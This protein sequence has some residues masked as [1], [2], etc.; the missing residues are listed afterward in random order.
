[1][2]RDV[3][4]LVGEAMYKYATNADSANFLD[5]VKQ[6]VSPSNL[7]PEQ[8]LARWSW[9]LVYQ[10]HLHASDRDTSSVQGIPELVT[11][12]V[13]Q[14]GVRE[15]QPLACFLTLQ[16]TSVGH[17]L[18]VVCSQ[19]L[20]QLEVLTGN[21]KHDAVLISLFNI[22]PLFVD[23]PDNL[24]MCTSFQNILQNLLNADRTYMKIAKSFIG[25]DFPGTVLKH[26][27]NMIEMQTRNPKWRSLII[28]WAKSFI[29][30]PNWN[31]DPGVLYLLNLVIRTGFFIPEACRG[32][33]V[34]FNEL[35][36]VIIIL[37]TTIND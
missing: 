22:V 20:E 6:A 34:V 30:L 26:F 1:M 31:R 15:Q 14:S 10:L 12:D 8:N 21:Y 7:S 11:V 23:C 35:L 16:M 25:T 28:F 2:H 36:E 13:L 9:Q 29:S 27:G 19:G 3:A 33:E 24:I 32:L 37:M 4:V 5:G 17:L 18:P